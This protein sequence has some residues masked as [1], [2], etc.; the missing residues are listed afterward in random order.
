MTK[1]IEFSKPIVLLIIVLNVLFAAAV[2]Y[3]FYHTAN[4][5]QA[6][7]GAWFAFTTV[8]LWALAK[9]KRDKIKRGGGDE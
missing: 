4:E 2:L 6:L 8:E 3:V 9:I 5:P 7:V 1:H